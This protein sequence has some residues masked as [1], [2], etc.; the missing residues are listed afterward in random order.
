MTYN[1]YLLPRFQV[2]C[3]STSLAVV[4]VAFAWSLHASGAAGEAET[5]TADSVDSPR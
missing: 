1:G 5:P 3:Q 2:L 4:F